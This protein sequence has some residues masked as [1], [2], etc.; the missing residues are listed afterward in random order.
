MSQWSELDLDQI[1]YWP[2]KMQWIFISLVTVIVCAAVA[3]FILLPDWQDYQ[4]AQAKEQEMLLQIRSKANLAAQLPIARERYRLLTNQLAL[5]SR[6]LPSQDELASLL[7]SITMVGTRNGMQFDRINWMTP[8]PQGLL[9]ALPL[10][11]EL[12]GSFSEL[13]QFSSDIALLP[14]II[15]LSDL[16]LERKQEENLGFSVRAT[17]FRLLSA[18]EL[19]AL[20]PAEVKP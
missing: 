10:Q 19:K 17:T 16:T 20:Q 4:D 18:D 11:L 9:Q 8:Q 1:A 14:R 6:Q 5:L 7:D 15:T 3:W 13:G 12:K 2:R